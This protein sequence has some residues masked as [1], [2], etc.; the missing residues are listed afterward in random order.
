[1]RSYP[2]NSPQAA[3]RIVALTMLADGHLA[4]SELD[5]I[6][7]Q[8][9]HEQ[10]GL[11]LET[12]QSVLHGF[13]EDLLHSAHLTWSDACR[14]DPR[15]L[16]QLMAEVDDP[17]LRMKV[18]QLCLKVVQADDHVAEGETIVLGAA[19]EHWGLHREMFESA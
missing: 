16:A 4:K 2:T 13:C 11:D 10:L 17:A 8:G 19:V 15:T 14:I 6:E 18:L 7:R 1:M 5:V 12:M 3:A 9:A